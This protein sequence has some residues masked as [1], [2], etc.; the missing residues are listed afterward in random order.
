M[1]PLEFLEPKTLEE[2]CSLL[3]KHK[4]EAKLIAGGQSLR[5]IMRH[6]LIA[7]KYLINLKGLSEMDYIKELS[8][9][10][11]IGAI[12]TH[13]AVETSS[14]IGKRFPILVEMERSLGS[15]Q[16]RNWGTVGGSLTHADPAGDPAPAL[17]A[18]G[19]SVKVVSTKGERELPLENFL[20]GYYETALEA[21]E[22]LTEITV[23]YLPPN[24]GGDYL[25]EVVRAGDIGIA[26]VA[27]QVTLNGSNEVKDARVVLGAQSV[28]PFRAKEAEKAA[29][30]KKAG[31]S[32]EE[33]GEAAAGEA[34]PQS[35]VLGSA[36]YKKEQ[37]K[38][39]TRR[40]LSLAV[41]RAQ[42][43]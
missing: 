8:G 40:A 19:A 20:T 38:V 11:K 35:D 37:A 16:V 3:S 28:S 32:F 9:E 30:G 31:D 13:R 33:A 14:I 25:K 24:S 7:P 34:N 26:N 29:I 4:E 17:I 15:V 12:T 41:S 22:I 10:L 39:L 2:A 42:A 21:D 1:K 18:V 6:Q 27:A 36:E 5:P 23:S 43:A